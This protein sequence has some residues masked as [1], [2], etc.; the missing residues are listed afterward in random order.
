MKI[1]NENGVTLVT[2]IIMIVVMSIIASVSIVGGVKVLREA[3]AQVKESNLAAVKAVVNREAAKAATAGVFTPASYNHYGTPA[4]GIVSGDADIL[5][6]WYLVDEENLKEMGVDYIGENYLVNYKANRV[7]ALNDYLLSGSLDAENALT[8][9]KSNSVVILAKNGTLKVGDYIDYK[10]SAVATYTTNPNNTGNAA[11]TFTADTGANWRILSVNQSTGEVIITT[12]GAVNNNFALS[13][14]KAYMNGKTELNNVCKSLYSN[15][16]MGLVARSMTVEDVNK[17]CGMN[18]PSELEPEYDGRYG[19]AY[20]NLG[21]AYYPIDNDGGTVYYN[22]KEY[23]RMFQQSETSR[24]YTYDGG[25]VETTDENGF[26]YRYSTEDNPVY[27]S[28]TSYKYD[29]NDYN[30]RVADVLGNNYGWLAS[31]CVSPKYIEF[32]V[33][34]DKI[35]LCYSDNTKNP[36]MLLKNKIDVAARLIPYYSLTHDIF[37][38][39]NG[40]LTN[41][42]LSYA[43]NASCIYSNYGI[44]PVVVL[45]SSS[46]INVDDTSRDGSSAEKAWSLIK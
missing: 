34:L 40:A 29:I 5:N 41:L 25:G 42:Q 14:I 39:M 16:D 9:E 32:V 17:A 26:K 1:K 12:E 27:V 20:Y 13:G 30:T 3:K 46:L 43:D 22:G 4:F 44:R 21:Y 28:R 15:N 23:M 19:D 45:G 2:V 38:V 33:K 35:Y 37:A 36:L 7:V 24:F 18:N 31:T 10:P 6:G 8:S 11:Q